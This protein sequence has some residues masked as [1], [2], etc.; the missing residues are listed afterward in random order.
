[1]TKWTRFIKPSFVNINV[2]DTFSTTAKMNTIGADYKSV[3]TPEIN[4]T[5]RITIIVLICLGTLH[6]Y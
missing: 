1:M 5:V 4:V 3:S 2:E 6:T